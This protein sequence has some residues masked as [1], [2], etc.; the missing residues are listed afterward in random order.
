M[1][2][3]SGLLLRRQAEITARAI[4]E[5]QVRSGCIPATPGGAADPWNHTEAA[6]ALD[7]AGLVEESERAYRW[8]AA[9]QRADGSWGMR[10]KGDLVSDPAADANFCAYVAT[11]AWHHYLATG[12]EAFLVELWPAVQAGVEFAL[13]LQ[14]PGGEILWARDAAGRPSAPA[15]LTSSS[16]IHLSLGCALEIASVL[17][18]ERPR[19]QAARHR[20][21]GAI[22]KRP[23]AFGDRARYSMDWYYPV[24]GGVLEGGPA[25]AR[26]AAGWDRYVVEGIGVRCVEDRPWVTVAESCE[27]VLALDSVGWREEALRV[28]GWIQELRGSSGAYWMGTTF[29]EGRLW[30]EEQPTWTSAAVLL[31]AD[32]LADAS[33]TAGLFKRLTAAA[34]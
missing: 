20:L 22:R 2:E 21:A 11:G 8:L 19:W 9:T 14:A 13:S 17:G 24:L 27:L 25:Q 34:A 15:L 31:A 12:K 33:A 23:E 3:I 10:Y 16:C 7:V 28:F 29:P 26:L 5:V 4:A 32:A 1:P 30:P 6:M 18:L